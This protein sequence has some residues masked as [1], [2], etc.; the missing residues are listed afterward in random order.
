MLRAN[1][2]VNTGTSGS[3]GI[4]AY[5]LPSTIIRD[6]TV[7]GILGSTSSSTSE[8]RGLSYIWSG[9]YAYKGRY[10]FDFTA[11]FNG[12]SRFG[13]NFKFGLFPGI[14]GKWIIS[15]EPFWDDYRHIVNMFA[16][17]PSWGIG[18]TSPLPNTCT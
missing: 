15:D 13:D 1:F 11:N 3:L 9:H 18:V 4:S 17:R 2:R 6:A 14:S 16:F 5:G 8:S 12:S 7:P 10:I